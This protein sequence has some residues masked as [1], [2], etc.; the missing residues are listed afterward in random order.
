[1]TFELHEVSKA[2]NLHLI[3]WSS[4]YVLVQ[5]K[6]RSDRYIYGPDIPEKEVTKILEN[7]YPD[8][9]FMSN[10][11]GKFKFHKIAGGK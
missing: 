6:G 5:F 8:R 10:I 2:R 9:L 1:M 4:G 7:P 11:K 3:G